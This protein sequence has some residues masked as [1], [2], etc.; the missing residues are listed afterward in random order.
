MQRYH[1][2]N[3][4]YLN[5]IKE[6]CIAQN[7]LKFFDNK[8]FWLSICFLILQQ[9]IVASST[10][11]IA[12]LSFDIATGKIFWFDLLL[13][14]A[15]LVVVYIPGTFSIYQLHRAK[16]KAFSRYILEF[17]KSHQHK[18]TEVGNREIKEKGTAFLSSESYLVL[19]DFSKFVYD[20]L[21]VSLNVALNV[22]AFG[23]FVESRLLI[24]YAIGFPLL[25]LSLWM[26]GATIRKNETQAQQARIELTQG[27]TLGWENIIIANSYNLKKWTELIETRFG[28][29]TERS[30]HSIKASQVIATLAMLLNMSPV[31]LCLGYLFF[32]N[33][34]HPA[35]LAILIATLPRQIQILQY[36]QVIVS[37]ATQ[38]NAMKARLE[39]LAFSLT[40]LSSDGN[41]LTRVSWGEIS[42]AWDGQSKVIPSHDAFLQ[43]LN[44]FQSGRL[45]LR[46][47]NGAGKSTLLAMAKKHFDSQAYY[48][49]AHSNLVFDK[50]AQKSLSTGEN[51]RLVLEEIKEKVDVPILLLDEWD[52]NLDTKNQQEISKLI[53]QLS[54]SKCVIEVRHRG[55]ESE[56]SPQ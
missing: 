37:Y 53:H 26:T 19:N 44:S 56:L 8:S 32:K 51:I 39:A 28:K 50:I 17:V 34:H 2:T 1:R 20:W 23:A 45:T 47:R 12:R 52:A 16:F 46:G 6:I 49:P 3:G 27:L 11:W 33:A 31:L 40:K 24:A 29:A 10:V 13:F 38:W 21:S 9:L 43:I 41:P 30:L 55:Q 54:Q 7:M 42:V 14:L 25:L 22:L 36:M 48:L 15:S 18:V 35:Y 4:K 5:T